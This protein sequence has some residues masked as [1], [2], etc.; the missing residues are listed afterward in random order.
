MWICLWGIGVGANTMI[1]N[2]NVWMVSCG[3]ET[4]KLYQVSVTLDMNERRERLEGVMFS[5][6]PPSLERIGVCLLESFPSFA[7][8]SLVESLCQLFPSLSPTRTQHSSDLES[9][10]FIL[11]WLCVYPW[12]NFSTHCFFFLLP[13]GKVLVPVSF[14]KLKGPVG[15]S[16][17][18]LVPTH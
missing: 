8:C 17:R 3:A 13:V 4:W 12:C 10:A 7:P 9:R 15:W 6:S 2:R 1:R 18:C 14:V 11:L 5:R 16:A